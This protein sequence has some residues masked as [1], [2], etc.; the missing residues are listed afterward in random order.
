MV[1]NP[2]VG[3]VGTWG[4]GGGWLAIKEVTRMV[5]TEMKIHSE[6]REAANTRGKIVGQVLQTPAPVGRG[7][8]ERM[9][10]QASFRRDAQY[11]CE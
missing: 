11:V 3:A 6:R 1:N 8:M 2:I 5:L 4:G 7:W 10:R 9:D